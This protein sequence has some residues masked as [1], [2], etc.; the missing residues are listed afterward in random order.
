MVADSAQSDIEHGHNAVAERFMAIELSQRRTPGTS[1]LR[2]ARQFQYVRDLLGTSCARAT[3]RCQVHFLTSTRS[4]EPVRAR[5]RV[6]F[7]RVLMI[8][9]GNHD[10]R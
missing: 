8:G 2:R 5:V 10:D 3:T 7:A 9:R 6:R 4:S 1:E